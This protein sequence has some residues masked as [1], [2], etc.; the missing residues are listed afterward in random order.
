MSAEGGPDV[1]DELAK[2]VAALCHLQG[3]FVLRSGR[4]APVYFDK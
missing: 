2:S 4:T 3:E 1:R